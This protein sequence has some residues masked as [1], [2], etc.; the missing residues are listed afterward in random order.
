M[1]RDRYFQQLE[2]HLPYLR[3]FAMSAGLD[4]DEANDVLSKCLL[5]AVEKKKYV[6]IDPPRLKAFLRSTIRYGIRHFKET[7]LRE[8]VSL[9]RLSDCAADLVD[10]EPS[11]L[12]L[13]HTAELPPIEE[14][15]C[16]FCFQANLNE[17]GACSMCHTILPSSIVV[18]RKGYAYSLESLAVEF[19]FNTVIDVQNAVQRLTPFE[20]KVVKAVGLGN[21]TLES[22][23]GY[24]GRSLSSV[25]RTWMIAKEKLQDYLKEYAPKGLS[26]R[27]ENAFRRA[28]QRIENQ[29]KLDA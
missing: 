27:G 2:E 10:D 16:P 17:Y 25:G 13:T 26:K 11:S 9:P 28:L 23:S 5:D 24:N 4:K 29:S 20:Q 22:F 3:K 18:Q 21:E 12:L 7:Q 15:E 19:D 6:S 14:V 1:R 8:R